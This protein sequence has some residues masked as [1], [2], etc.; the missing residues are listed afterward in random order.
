MNPRPASFR[1]TL[2]QRLLICFAL[3]ALLPLLL[4]VFLSFRNDRRQILQNR[5]Q[6]ANLDVQQIARDLD[7]ELAGYE[8]VL[9]QLYTDD[10]LSDLVLALDQGQDLAV[11]RN[12][13]RR[14]LRSVFWLQDYIASITVITRSSG[15]SAG[16]SA[17]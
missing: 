14:K 13:I 10:E 2:R 17:N 9:Y 4:N 12:Q 8:N 1:G 5:D 7:S 16:W 6:I 15:A 11:T 3:V